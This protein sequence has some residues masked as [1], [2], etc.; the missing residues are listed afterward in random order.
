MLVWQDQSL[1]FLGIPKDTKCINLA[2]DFRP[3]STQ[4]R[5]PAAGFNNSQIQFA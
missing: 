3:E 5:K 4:G 1:Q 2:A